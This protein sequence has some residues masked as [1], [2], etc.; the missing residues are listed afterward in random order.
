MSAGM[1]IDDLYEL[2]QPIRDWQQYAVD[3][4]DAYRQAEERYWATERDNPR[5]DLFRIRAALA[6]T[7]LDA[8]LVHFGRHIDASQRIHRDDK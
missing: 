6:Q 5:R 7:K 3:C 1:T 4:A 8:A 2:Q